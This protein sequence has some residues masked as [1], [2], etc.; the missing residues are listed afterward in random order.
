MEGSR[1]QKSGHS[2][3]SRSYEDYVFNTVN[4][5]MFRGIKQTLLEFGL[6]EN[7]EVEKQQKKERSEFNFA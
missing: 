5:S 1:H 2:G 7:R 3:A 4:D 6:C